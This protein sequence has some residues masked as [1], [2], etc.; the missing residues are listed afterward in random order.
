MPLSYSTQNDVEIPLSQS[1]ECNNITQYTLWI[2]VACT[3]SRQFRQLNTGLGAI[4]QKTGRQMSAMN[5]PKASLRTHNYSV[6]EC[7]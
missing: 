2:L 1:G 6:M 3:K 4:D 7:G 5:R